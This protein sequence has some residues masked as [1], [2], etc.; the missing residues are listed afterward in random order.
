MIWGRNSSDEDCSDMMKQLLS[1]KKTHYTCDGEDA[2]K[3]ILVTMGQRETSVIFL[4]HNIKISTGPQEKLCNVYG[5]QFNTSS[6]MDT[7]DMLWTHSRNSLTLL[8]CN[9]LQT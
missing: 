4:W 8:L 7:V 6:T 2:K 1:Q 9:T 5:L 3:L